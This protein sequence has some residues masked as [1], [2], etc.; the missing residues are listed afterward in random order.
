MP[1]VSR[2]TYLSLGAAAL[3]IALSAYAVASSRAAASAPPPACSCAGAAQSELDRGTGAPVAGVDR[4][5]ALA[6]AGLSE[7]LSRLEQERS[8]DGHGPSAA[9]SAAAASAAT[10]AAA[11]GLP[12]YE[13]L[14]V[15][16]DAVKVRQDEAGALAVTNTDPALTGTRMIVEARLEDGTTT[17]VSIIVPAPEGR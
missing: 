14:T 13:S 10:P 7:R 2:L 3:S 15:T 9:P 4:G 12:R 17:Q 16:N 6:I 5:V 8:S 1:E 11:R